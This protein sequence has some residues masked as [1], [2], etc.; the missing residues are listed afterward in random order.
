MTDS[1]GGNSDQV[2]FE[3]LEF[4]SAGNWNL[5]KWYYPKCFQTQKYVVV[6]IYDLDCLS[7]FSRLSSYHTE[8][9]IKVTQTAYGHKAITEMYG[10]LKWLGK[11]CR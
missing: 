6:E 11:D 5:P 9:V 1:V 4:F 2:F 7:A 8:P 3:L 10:R